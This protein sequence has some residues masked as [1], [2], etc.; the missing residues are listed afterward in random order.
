MVL[1][2]ALFSFYNPVE[3]SE[4][5]YAK[6]VKSVMLQWYNLSL[7]LESK[8]LNAYPPITAERY[9]KMGIGAYF[10]NHLQENVDRNSKLI[11]LNDLYAHYLELF[12]K[13]IK[14][15]DFDKINLLNLSISNSLKPK[16]KISKESE[17]ELLSKV[18]S[19]VDLVLNQPSREIKEV[20]KFSHFPKYQ[21]K[22][23]DPILPDWANAKSSVIVDKLIFKC[24]PPYYNKSSFEKAIYEDALS[25]YAQSQNLK[26][27]DIWIAEFWSDDI[28][29]LTF[30]PIG[31]WVNIT[32]NIVSNESLKLDELIDLY[33][34]LGVGFY[35]AAVVCW[36]NKY[37]YQIERPQ[38]FI[39]KRIDNQWKSLHD[40]PNFPSYPS[41]HSIFGAVSC[42]I[43]ENQFG[44]NYAFTDDSHDNRSEFLGKKRSFH[45]IKEMAI[46]NAFSRV[47]MGVH[48]KN[49]CEEGLRLGFEIG[50]LVNKNVYYKINNLISP[51]YSTLKN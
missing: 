20:Y 17:V 40:A 5:I 30:S 12:F 29:G 48:Y 1:L 32:N 39:Q 44:K 42:E 34:K 11:L 43:L 46:E 35:D 13:D 9:A 36:Y 10:V 31:R 24:N 33:L 2:L 47:L 45:N 37:K 3:N 49:D 18:T 41:G 16:S 51:T 21:F 38:E 14:K 6:E 23:T 28:R 7:Q 15:E 27:E 50:N 4:K 8:D 26:N 25:L 22:S 19:K